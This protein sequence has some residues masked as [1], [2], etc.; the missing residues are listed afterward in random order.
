MAYRKK[1]GSQKGGGSEK[2][3]EAIS[4]ALPEQKKSAQGVDVNG[5]H[6]TNYEMESL[7]QIDEQN[8]EL[9]GD[10]I[11]ESRKI[12]NQDYFK[13][14]PKE[15]GVTKEELLDAKEALK[16][17]RKHDIDMERVSRGKKRLFGDAFP[18]FR[19]SF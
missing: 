11:R 5:V 9:N 15:R 3:K 17:N 13:A 16:Q 7:R 1:K 4:G 19:R 14:L 2:G 8:L 12:S 18:G 10:E 6:L